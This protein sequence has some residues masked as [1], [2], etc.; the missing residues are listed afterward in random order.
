MGH[1]APLSSIN[2]KNHNHNNAYLTTRSAPH[3]KNKVHL[4]SRCAGPIY[5]H[6][7]K[8]CTILLGAKLSPKGPATRCDEIGHFPAILSF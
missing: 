1:Q 7:C 8:T 5:N 3:A 2:P 4:N 6:T